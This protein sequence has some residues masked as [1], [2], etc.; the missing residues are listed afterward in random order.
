MENKVGRLE[1]GKYADLVVLSEDLFQIDP[2]EIPNVQVDLTMVNGEIV[3]R[4][5]G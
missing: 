4:N 2:L 5:E 3:F 1:Q